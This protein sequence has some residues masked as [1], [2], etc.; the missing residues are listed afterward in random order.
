MEHEGSQNNKQPPQKGQ[1]RSNSGAHEEIPDLSTPSG[2]LTERQRLVIASQQLRG[3]AKTVALIQ[4]L[5]TDVVVPHHKVTGSRVQLS[6]I[7]LAP[8]SESIVNQAV[9]NAAGTTVAMQTNDYTGTPGYS[10]ERR[11][12][13]VHITVH[14]LFLSPPV[15]TGNDPAGNPIFPNP[16]GSPI[17]AN[18]PRRAGVVPICD[19][20]TSFWN[21]K[22]ELMGHPLAPAGGSANGS[23]AAGTPG[24]TGAAGQ[25]PEIVLPLSFE[26]VP[27]WD[28]AQP[29]D[30]ARAV[31]LHGGTDTGD[32]SRMDP[33]R[34]TKGVNPSTTGSAAIDAGNW[35][36]SRAPG[37]YGAVPAGAAAGTPD[38]VPLEAIYAH[39][40][41]HLLGLIDEYSQSSP[42]THAMLH[43]ISPNNQ[44]E[45]DRMDTDLDRATSKVIILEA[46]RPQLLTAINT[47]SANV[48]TAVQGQQQLLV[49]QLTTGLRTS[50]RSAEITTA[51]EQDVQA[52]LAGQT[53]VQGS[54]H[55]SVRTALGTLD[56]GQ[57]AQQVV[58]SQLNPATVGGIMSN[59]MAAAVDAAQN[60]GKVSINTISGPVNMVINT[61]GILTDPALNQLRTDAQAA[62]T[63]LVGTAP[64][65]APGA[66][67]PIPPVS[68]SQNLIDQL[69]SV[70]AQWRTMGSL[71][72]P[73][74]INTSVQQ[75]FT[76]ILAD[77]SLPGAV[78]D[79][80][81]QLATALSARLNT[82]A[83]AAGVQ[84]I[85]RFLNN[86]IQ[87]QIQQQLDMILQQIAT[88]P[89]THGTATP[90]GTTGSSTTPPPDPAM[91][92][93]VNDIHTRMQAV[94]AQARAVR[95]TPEKTA[96]TPASPGVAATP[97]TRN[98]LHVDITTAGMMG[99][100]Y[101]SQ[102]VRPDY[103]SG[104]ANAFNHP[105]GAATDLRHTATESEFTVRPWTDTRG[106]YPIP[107][108]TGNNGNE[109]LA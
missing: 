18:D 8:S 61:T 33:S 15:T 87:P 74:A 93:R 80:P 71:F 92:A 13:D 4:R 5:K 20:L 78:N 103:M 89:S 99:D 24:G 49:Q 83:Q 26:A 60:N 42:S 94:L 76:A 101:A 34:S 47:I 1:V 68:P 7:K 104:I 84:S 62:A 37:Q 90:T 16:N 28:P 63:G 40:Y 41:G 88:E 96:G 109:A 86:Q 23:G 27:V 65:L 55:N 22:Y 106:D 51:L 85:N 32:S 56:F 46:M 48:A 10:M 70:A 102:A 2:G 38:T 6:A 39:E 14:I 77:G 72:D 95:D 57:I 31:Y 75:A 67:G 79:H 82:S 91:Q 98:N 36:L 97:A 53:H 11:M 73:A 100:N 45:K 58:T 69:M 35:Y 30:N 17:P 19:G 66:A 50:W 43:G 59:L 64:A 21:H 29:H 3:N 105:T 12:L 81:N 107:S 25:N 52:Q 54:L 108:Q 9:N 44:A